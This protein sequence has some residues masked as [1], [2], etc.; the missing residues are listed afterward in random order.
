MEIF[1]FSKGVAGECSPKPEQVYLVGA[2][3]S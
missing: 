2:I 1:V 3:H